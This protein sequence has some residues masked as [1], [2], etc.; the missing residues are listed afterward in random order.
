[1]DKVRDKTLDLINDFLDLLSKNKIKIQKAY[2]YGSYANKSNNQYSDID[3]ALVS[4]DFTGDLW[5]DKRTLREFKS[6]VS[7]DISP[8]P[9]KVSEFEISQFAKDDIIGKGVRII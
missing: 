8:M 9:Y 1:M 7:W 2:L 5:E 6:L 3:L 4:D